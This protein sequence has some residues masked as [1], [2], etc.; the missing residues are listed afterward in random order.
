MNPIYSICMC[1]Y[2]MARTLGQ[3]VDSIA[4][5]LDG[6]FEIVLVDDGSSD[7]SVPIMRELAARYPII[8]VVALNRDRKRKL[9]ETRNVSIR[10]ARGMYCLLH[11]DCDDGW[12]SHLAAWIEVFHQIEVAIGTDILLA[13]QQVH[14]AKRSLLLA[15]GPYPNIFR[16]EDRAMYTRFSALELLWFL[17]HEVFRARLPHP[18]GKSLRR[19]AVYTIDHMTTDFR[20]GAH[21][22]YYICSEMKKAKKR[23][24]K[25]ILLRLAMLPAAWTLSKCKPAILYGPKLGHE[26]FSNYRKEHTDNF[27]GLMRRHNSAP[28]WSRLPS[29]SRSI[30]ER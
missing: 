20:S 14:I 24:L 8:R 17:D 3:A 2:N 25:L 7:D 1:N 23:T 4:V 29:S 28:D 12:G 6:R 21:F 10:E 18:K 11:L 5:Q 16:G 9:G 22:G 13:G 27:S 26:E 19:A 30:F 15:H